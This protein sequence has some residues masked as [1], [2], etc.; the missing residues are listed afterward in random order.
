VDPPSI[1]I[2]IAPADTRVLI[3]KFAPTQVRA[4]SAS[5]SITSN[6]PG[7]PFV[8]VPLSGIGA[9]AP[10]SNLDVSVAAVDFPSGSSV[11]NI[12]VRNTGD[13]DLMIGSIQ[14]PVTPFA[15]TGVPSLPGTFKPG[16]GFTMSLS[17]SPT[18]SGIFDS[19]I[20][21]TSN[22]PD[23][24]VLV[25]PVRGT[26]T[27]TSELLKLRAPSIATAIAGQ[28]NTFFVL[29]SNGTNSDIRLSA[30]PGSGG[31][32]TDRGNGK[33]DL[34]LTPA[35]GSANV[36]VLFTARDGAN[37]VK[38]IQST[39]TVVTAANT[40]QV[41]VSWVAPATA[42]T[43][44]TSALAVPS[45]ITP[46][47]VQ[48]SGVVP[49]DAAGLV[50]YVV[51][52]S[53]SPGVPVSLANI[54]GV[55]PA[56]ALTYNDLLPVPPGPTVAYYVVTALYNTGTESGASNETTN[57]PIIK[58]LAYKGK[59]IKFDGTNA[60]VAVGATLT[61]DGAQTFSLTRDADQLV[62]PKNA[63]STPGNLRPKD[64]VTPGSHSIRVTNPNGASNTATLVR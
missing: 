62:V 9:G 6:D 4:Y 5:I 59:S 14:R 39:I 29:A 51:Y 34:V 18:S 11:I 57:G 17:F 42:P 2:T 58:N 49:A 19:R 33:G 56:P 26:S 21:I 30:S 1:P 31:T 15:L 43:A 28:A 10:V 53:N 50:G 8:T 25:I 40:S 7:H 27:P 60:N 64:V 54:V 24:L 32:F 55:I 23:S 12:E 16:D 45:Y 52:R 63:R 41:R 38:S 3:V 13:A 46:L 61:V 47:S 35:A 44:P 36:N 22:D 20:T 37:R 48:P